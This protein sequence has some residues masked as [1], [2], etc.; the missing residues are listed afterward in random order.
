MSI[1]IIFDS[2]RGQTWTVRLVQQGDAYG[3]DEQLVHMDPE[4][5]VEFFDTRYAHTD[6]GQFVSRY[7]LSTLLERP[8]SDGLHLDLG[9]PSWFISGPAMYEVQVWLRAAAK[10]PP[11]L[12]FEAIH[13]AMLRKVL[14]LARAHGLV[15]RRWT[16]ADNYWSVTV[17]PDGKTAY[18]DYAEDSRGP[19]GTV[20]QLTMLELAN[21]LSA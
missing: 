21:L 7:N 19:T 16:H 17:Y 4:P 6:L 9:I 12:G 10:N 2:V 20:A 5:L 13:G 18:A 15:E 1:K 8:L 11:T 14:E 3:L